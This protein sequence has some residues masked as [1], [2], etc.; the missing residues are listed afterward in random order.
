MAQP[1]MTVLPVPVDGPAARFIASE[2]VPPGRNPVIQAGELNCIGLAHE[3]GVP[4][5]TQD[6]NA[7]FVAMAALGPGRVLLP[8]DL[9]LHMERQGLMVASDRDKLSDIAWR[10]HKER[11]LVRP[12]RTTDGRVPNPDES[13]SLVISGA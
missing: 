2:L 1:W 6:K 10:N 12:S 3:L 4:F 8:Y 13:R 5:V 11:V 9:W 7:V